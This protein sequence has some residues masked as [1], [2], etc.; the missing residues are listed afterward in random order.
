MI[1]KLCVKA[2]YG[3]KEIRLHFPN[4]WQVKVVGDQRKALNKERIRKS[5]NSSLKSKIVSGKKVVILIDDLTRPTP[6]KE[7]IP[8]VLANIKKQVPLSNIKIVIAGGTHKPL[9]KVSIRKKV[10]KIPHKIQVI[11]HNCQKDLE[12]HGHTKRGTPIYLNKHVAQADYK[13]GIGCIYP[14]P[15][16]GYS[17]GSKILFPGVAG[18]Q[19]ATYLHDYIRGATKRG[20]SINCEFRNEIDDIAGQ[21]GLDRIINVTFNH[22]REIAGIFVGDLKKAFEEGVNYANENY[23][24]EWIHDADIIITDA[25]PFD[26]NLNFA[27]DRGFWP[28]IKANKKTTKIA[29]AMCP[30]GVGDHELFPTSNSLVKRVSR[31]IKNINIR[32]L[33]DLKKKIFSI[34]NIIQRNK[35]DFFLLSDS[36]NETDLK[37]SFPYAKV[38]K[39]WDKILDII[40]MKY[41][42]K[43]PIVT[44]YRCAPLYYLK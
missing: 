17:G 40:K 42:G 20:G 33:R 1:Q 19:T 21:I 28:I 34:R 18:L 6:C 8:I 5:I 25:Y 9:N 3:D 31:R 15:A 2:W 43:K 35:M 38:Y 7:I 11:A 4:D 36:I 13:I 27:R 23:S 14:H 22:K 30:E 10:G 44:I 37:K 29:I 24:V 41:N 26:T 12:F 39:K 32:E 16:A